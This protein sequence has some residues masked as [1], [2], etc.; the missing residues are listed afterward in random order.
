MVRNSQTNNKYK[1]YSICRFN[2]DKIQNDFNNFRLL[3]SFVIDLNAFN[4][5]YISYS[6]ISGFYKNMIKIFRSD[7]NI[8]LGGRWSKELSSIILIRYLD[9][10]S[11]SDLGAVGLFR[12]EHRDGSASLCGAFVFFYTIIYIQ[13]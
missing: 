3:K 1:A 6:H 12:S 11:V 5:K 4:T 9:N 7:L 2:F 8:F 13:L 10:L